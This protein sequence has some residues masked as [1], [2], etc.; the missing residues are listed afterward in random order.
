VP[1]IVGL[2]AAAKLAL[3][4]RERE[5]A[6]IAAL[7]ERL[8]RGAVERLRGCEAV[9]HPTERLPGLVC[10]LVAGIEGEA[11]VLALDAEGIAS[12]SGSACT[13]G[14]LEPSHVLLAMG[15]PAERAHGS[16]RLSL[17]RASAEAEVNRFLEVFPPI[18]E[19]L[20]KMSPTWKG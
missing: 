9:G 17:G 7:A 4:E 19:R 8:R 13:S 10:I 3:A 2:G 6:R 5:S 15:I 20:R 18:V 11:M 1:G 12:S 14:S 16:L